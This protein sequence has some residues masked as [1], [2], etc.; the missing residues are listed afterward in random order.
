MEDYDYHKH[1]GELPEYFGGGSGDNRC[2]GFACFVAVIL[3]SG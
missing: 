2:C 3:L 1:T